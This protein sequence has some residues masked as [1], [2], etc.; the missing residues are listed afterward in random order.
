MKRAAPRRASD[1]T[2]A[3]PQSLDVSGCAVDPAGV[4]LQLDTPF[5]SPASDAQPE[6][7]DANAAAVA[8]GDGDGVRRLTRSQSVSNPETD[9]AQSTAR[10]LRRTASTETARSASM[11]RW[12]SAHTAVVM[13]L[14]VCRTF[15]TL[16]DM[17]A[18]TYIQPE[19]LKRVRLLG[20]GAYSVVELA[21]L[22]HSSASGDSK[23]AVLAASPVERVAVKRLRAEIF[24][25]E[26][27]YEMFS[28]E[29]RLLRK[30]RHRWR[31]RSVVCSCN[32][33]KCKLLWR[34]A[35]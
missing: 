21:E 30:L 28:R 17:V 9:G 6:P 3:R 25:Q 23:D 7:Q 29:V 15:S 1:T 12:N 32:A 26:G 27:E 31:S 34:N 18:D 10:V 20:Q 24:S 33:M 4:S 11:E 35:K 2:M 8:G 19:R 13:Q 16:R 14:R 5:A 22:R